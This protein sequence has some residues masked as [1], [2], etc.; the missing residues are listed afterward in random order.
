MAESVML[1][2]KT[3]M[4][5]PDTSI[6]Y[7]GGGYIRFER[8]LHLPPRHVENH[9]FLYVESGS[10][11]FIIPDETLQLDDRMLLL[12]SPG[13]REI[14][15]DDKRPVSYTYIEFSVTRDLVTDPWLQVPES[16]PHFQTLIGLLH[17]TLHED[18]HGT[19]S[20]IRAAIDLALRHTAP[21]PDP[22]TP[23]VDGRI[24]QV[25]DYIDR[26]LNRALKVSEL[27]ELAGLSEPQFRRVFRANMSIGPKEYL[28]RTRMHYARCILENEGLRVSDVAELLQ[29]ETV[30]QF[31]KQYKKIHAHSPTGRR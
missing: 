3:I 29:F 2:S 8:G 13:V 12:L 4:T 15:Y 21:T 23:T 24:R 16:S 17:S 20:V 5:S 6:A 18:G 27:A 1:M 30:Y 11:E 31:S 19:E 28:L 25:L 26:N 9:R 14:R 7:V 10:G 22:S